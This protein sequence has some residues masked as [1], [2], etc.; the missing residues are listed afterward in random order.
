MLQQLLILFFSGIF[1]CIIA[2]FICKQRA[3][4][5]TLFVSGGL[6]IA[7]PFALLLYFLT[8]IFTS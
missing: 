1:L 3:L 5:I 8:I 6:L 7:L 2:Y 4:R